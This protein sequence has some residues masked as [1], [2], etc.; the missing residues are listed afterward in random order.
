MMAVLPIIVG[1]QL[2]LAAV[3][4]DVANVPDEPIQDA[5]EYRDPSSSLK[6]PEQKVA[7]G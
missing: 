3:S 5:L 2:L 6:I 1:V 4:L 7:N